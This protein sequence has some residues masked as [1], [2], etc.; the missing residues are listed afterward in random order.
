MLL[1]LPDSACSPV[2]CVCR[3]AEVWGRR[4]MLGSDLKVVAEAHS[5]GLGSAVAVKPRGPLLL[6][7]QPL[8]Q[9]LSAGLSKPILSW[10]GEQTERLLHSLPARKRDKKALC[11]DF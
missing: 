6:L 2:H 4:K 7:L 9:T 5:L 8:D 11:F 1:F 3:R 10:G